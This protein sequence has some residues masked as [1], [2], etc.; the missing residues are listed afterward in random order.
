MI[1]SITFPKAYELVLEKETQK[2]FPHKTIDPRGDRYSREKEPYDIFELFPKDLLIEFNSGVNLIVGENGSGKT[3]LISLIKSYVGKPFGEHF[4][5]DAKWR[6]EEYYYAHYQDDYDG[7]LQVDVDKRRAT[8]KNTIFFNGEEDNPVTAIPKMAN[9]MRDD[10]LSLSAQLFFA[11]EESHGESM[12]PPI[13]YILTEAKGGYIIFM[14][15]PETALSLGNQIRLA[16]M[17][18]KSAEEYGNQLII[19]THS[20]A[21]INEFFTIFD[22]ETRKWVNREEYVNEILC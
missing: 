13:N 8:Y 4:S 1:K 3:T 19:S 11:Q 10:F 21:I 5:F 14:D 12:L 18:K 16:N 15:E 6:D 20:L 17:L 2:R 9:P 7:Y 22:M